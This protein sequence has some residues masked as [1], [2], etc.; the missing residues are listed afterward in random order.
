L[1]TLGGDDDDDDMTIRVKL[2]KEH[3]CELALT[4]AGKGYESELTVLWNQQ[5][6]NNRTIP[7]NKPDIII[8]DN[9]KGTCLITDRH[10][11]RQKCDQD[12]S[13]KILKYRDMYNFGE[14]C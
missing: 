7:N 11:R 5:V 8:R 12:R 13:R 2:D 3:C 10:F 1:R 4:V 9:V 6:K 14:C